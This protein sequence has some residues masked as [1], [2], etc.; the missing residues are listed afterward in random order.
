[1]IEYKDDV[2]AWI[3]GW[4][5]WTAAILLPD[6]DIYVSMT[7]EE[8]KDDSQGEVVSSHQYMRA[9]VTYNTAL[10]DTLDGH[11]RVVHE[12]CHPFLSKMEA[13]ADSLITSKTTRKFWVHYEDAEETVVVKLSKIMVQLRLQQQGDKDGTIKVT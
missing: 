3:R 8:D 5:D 7:S 1:M 9:Y 2:P 10:K 11:I 4:V 12:L 13:V 6:W